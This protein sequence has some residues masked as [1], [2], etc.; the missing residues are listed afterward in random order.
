MAGVTWTK[1]RTPGVYKRPSTRKPNES[2]YRAVYRDATGRQV[3]KNFKRLADAETFKKSVD[4]NRPEDVAAGRVPL[5]EVYREM[6][7]AHEAAQEPYAASTL[8]LYET[9]WRLHLAPLADKPISRITVSEVDKVLAAVEKPAMRDKVRRVLSTTFT[10]AVDR[11]PPYVA[12]SPVRLERKRTTRAARMRQ[13]EQTGK[14]YRLLKA[15]ELAKLLTQIPDRY[16]AL[17]EVMAYCG[18]RPGEGVSLRVGKFNPLKR[19]L[20]IDTAIDGFTKTGA[21]RTLVLPPAI[22]EMLTAQIATFSDPSN[23]DALIFT[24]KD[25]TGL[26][27]K[28]AYKA[29]ARH[30]FGEAAKEADVNHGLSPN[31]LR[32][33][34]ASFA[35]GHGADVFSVQRMLGHAKPSITLDIYAREWETSAETLAENL[36]EPIRQARAAGPTEAKVVRL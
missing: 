36:D 11:K 32:H 3:T 31:D 10:Y 30:V 8:D 16:K 28:P 12:A 9:V 13:R 20:L 4:V 33:Y 18:L 29:W 35:I 23:P 34:A 25:G 7:A 27:T 5:I 21:A 17:V 22:A 15:E 2:I 1:T 26:N 19:E 6:V 14:T 24:K